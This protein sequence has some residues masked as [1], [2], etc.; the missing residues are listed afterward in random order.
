MI[1][2]TI[3]TI[4]TLGLW[5]CNDKPKDSSADQTTEPEI[6]TTDS[7]YNTINL[8]FNNP[9][10][11]DSSDW[12]LYPLTLEALEETEKGFKS[13]SYERQSAYWNIAFFNTKTKQARLLSDSLKMLINSFSPKNYVNIESGQR[14]KRNEGLIYY[15]ITTKDFNQ[16]EKLNSDDPKYLF[17]SDLS[18]QG[19][20]QISPDNFDLIDLHIIH[21]SNKIL[22]Q[23]RKDINNDKK[24]DGDDE[25]VSFIYGINNQKNEPVFSDEFNLATK[26]LLDKQWTKKK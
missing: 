22:I 5:A 13:S 2:L 4:L 7:K 24:F 9:T 20:K 6:E 19:F 11:L 16:D 25:T 17:I 10:V 23:A 3:L 8:K 14:E 15:S 21:K 26:K 1:R 12:V 18:G